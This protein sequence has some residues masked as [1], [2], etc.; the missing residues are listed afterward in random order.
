M[1]SVNIIPKHLLNPL[2]HM[3]MLYSKSIF[4]APSYLFF[5]FCTSHIHCHASNPSINC[6]I[7]AFKCCDMAISVKDYNSSFIVSLYNH[8]T[9]TR[10]SEFIIY[11]PTIWREQS[12]NHFI[13][14]LRAVILT[15]ETA[16]ERYMRFED[17]NFAISNV[18]KYKSG[19]DS[20]VRIAVTGFETRGIYQTS[21]ISCTIPYYKVLIPHAL[22]NLLEKEGYDLSLVCVKRD[23]SIKTTCM[24]VCMVEKHGDPEHNSLTI[25]DSMAKGLNQDQDGDKNAIYLLPKRCDSYNTTSS[26]SYI[27]AKLELATAF[28]KMISLIGTPRYSISETNLMVIER[29]RNKLMDLIFTQRTIHHGPAFMI[30]AGCGYLRNEYEEFLERLMSYNKNPNHTYITADDLILKT[31]RLP[32]IVTSGAKGRHEHLNLLLNKI[33]D[34][35][36][37]LSDCEA[38]MIELVNRYIKSSQDLSHNGRN[39]FAS[40]YAAT[41]LIIMNGKIFLNK[42]FICD[43]SPFAS[44]GTFMW[45]DASLTLFTEDLLRL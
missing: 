32:S 6:F 12:F 2:W 15:P 22:Y 24:F 30:D 29:N 42:V 25:C 7:H 3:A 20:V 28:R 36:T 38:D 34:N 26:Y 10:D 35:N 11:D 4:T 19:K 16:K 8:S 9:V 23:P 43:Y 13:S 45:S 5:F 1:W 17:S 14:F 37:T 27:L 33:S 40:L 41:D 21:T 39:Q 31:N 44:C 18:K